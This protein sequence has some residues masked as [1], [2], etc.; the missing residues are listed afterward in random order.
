MWA[1]LNISSCCSR[2]LNE[3]L[4][5]LLDSGLLEV[6]KEKI[7]DVNQI[8]NKIVQRTKY[9]LPDPRLQNSIIPLDLVTQKVLLGFL[10][11]WPGH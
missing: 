7:L 10:N 3:A 6:Y 2:F 11:E 8:S 1:W 4:Q 9:L 5:L